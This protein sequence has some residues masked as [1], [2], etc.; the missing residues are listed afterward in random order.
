MLHPRIVR[1][2]Q[3]QADDDLERRIKAA[4][5]ACHKAKQEGDRE[6]AHRQW[7]K[8]VS[9]IAGRSK[10]QVGRMERARGLR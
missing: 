8:F 5:D 9:L 10:K 2:Y 1:D 6:E 4:L 7:H 3:A